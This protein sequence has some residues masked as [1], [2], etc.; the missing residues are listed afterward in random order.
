VY[1]LWQGS[2]SM[3]KASVFLHIPGTPAHELGFDK[4]DKASCVA[5][6]KPVVCMKP[7]Q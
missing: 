3:Y 1:G 4:A 6:Y 2:W 7:A 5:L